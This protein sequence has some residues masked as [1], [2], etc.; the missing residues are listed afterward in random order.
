[1]PLPRPSRPV[2]IEPE[3]QPAAPAPVAVPS[4]ALKP[5]DTFLFDPQGILAQELAELMV[6]F[7]NGIRIH[8][9]V[10]AKLPENLQKQFKHQK[11]S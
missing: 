7:F 2:E 8:H 1:M 3:V 4:R 10:F 6:V 11:I 9:T 5:S